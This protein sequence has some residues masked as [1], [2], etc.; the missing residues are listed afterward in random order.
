MV[1]VP[2]TFPAPEGDGAGEPCCGGWRSWLLDSKQV[3]GGC[4]SREER[5]RA[6]LGWVLSPGPGCPPPP[7]PSRGYAQS[8]EGDAEPGSGI[9]LLTKTR[10]GT[11]PLSV[12]R[13]RIN[14]RGHGR[15]CQRRGLGDVWAL[16]VCHFFLLLLMSILCTNM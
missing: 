1:S 6:L 9:H 7:L 11:H 3:R 16:C 8:Q 10:P 12:L 4:S 5:G 13:G 2:V 15:A 14:G